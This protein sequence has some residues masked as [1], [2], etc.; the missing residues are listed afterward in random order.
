MTDHI[1]PT[2]PEWQARQRRHRHN[3]YLGHCRMAMMNMNSIIVSDTTTV[4]AKQL[5]KRIHALATQLDS[6]LRKRRVDPKAKP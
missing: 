5:A 3:S 1:K 4:E 6:A 2:S